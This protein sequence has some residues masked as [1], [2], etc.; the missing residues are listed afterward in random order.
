MQPVPVDSINTPKLRIKA[1]AENTTVFAAESD[2]GGESDPGTQRLLNGQLPEGN[3]NAVE[4]LLVYSDPLHIW[5]EGDH[6]VETA[7]RRAEVG[8]YFLTVI[9]EATLYEVVEINDSEAKDAT[10]FRNV[11]E[12]IDDVQD[13]ADEL[14]LNARYVLSQK[15]SASGTHSAPRYQYETEEALNMGHIPPLVFKPAV[16]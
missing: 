3:T 7:V 11:P 8:K 9:G 13:P 15:T 5:L 14:V 12:H 1:M 4:F 6:L 10:E 16:D 2:E